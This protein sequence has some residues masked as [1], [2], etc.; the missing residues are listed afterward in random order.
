MRAAVMRSILFALSGIALASPAS[1]LD[2]NS[3]RAQHRLPPLTYSSALA[4]VAQAHAYD[5]ARRNH[6]DH[7]GFRARILGTPA[8]ENVGYGCADQACAFAHWARSA[9]H[10]RNMLMHGIGAYGIADAVSASGRHY[11][12]LELGN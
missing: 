10:R 9:G 5:L 11:W 3:L 2:I 6:L 8:A 4:A 7:R 1:A 12:V